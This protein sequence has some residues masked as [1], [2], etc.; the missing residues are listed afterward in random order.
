[1]VLESSQ[2]KVILGTYSFIK[3][4][5][6]VECSTNSNLSVKLNLNN[7]CNIY[8]STFGRMGDFCKSDYKSVMN[9]V[10]EDISLRLIS[11]NVFIVN[12]YL[13]YNIVFSKNGF[14]E[15]IYF[16]C[17]EDKT[18]RISFTF[19]SKLDNCFIIV[20]DILMSIKALN[21]V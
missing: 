7:G 12:E 6:G 20:K 16:V 11:S 21:N 3:P 13:V 17:K 15:S 8:V 4:K 1:M 19:F 18:F 10:N 5:G 14:F 2:E 9:N